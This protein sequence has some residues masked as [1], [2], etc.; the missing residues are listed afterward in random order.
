MVLLPLNFLYCSEQKYTKNN[1]C[2]CLDFGMI[3]N[4]TKDLCQFVS[5]MFD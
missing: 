5:V 1:I 2:Y 3:V 4:G